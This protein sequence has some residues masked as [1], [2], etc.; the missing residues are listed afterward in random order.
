MKKILIFYLLIVNLVGYSQDNRQIIDDFAIKGKEL[1][2]IPGMSLV[3][4]END[5]T[6]FKSTYG[7][8]NY[9]TK[10]EVDDKTIFSMASTT[11]AFIGMGLGILVD[12]DSIGWNDKVV[13]HLPKFKLSD[14]Y[15]SNDARVKDLLTHNLGIGNEDRLWTTDSTSIDELLLNF[16]KSERKYSL[17]G[18]YTYQNIMY[19][20]AGRLIEKVSG[21]SWQDFI[22]HNI[23][24]PIGLECTLTWSKDIFEYGNHT[25]PH[26]IDYEEGIVN[27]P[28]TISDQ[29]GA[30]GMMWSC[31]D[32]MEKY[33]Y[34]LLNNSEVDGK[35]ILSEKTFNYIFEPQIIIGSS[36]YP[37]SKLTKPNWRTYG[38]GWFQHDYRGLKIDMHT[39]SL[40]GLVAIIAMVRDK[41][42]GLQ[43]FANMDGAELRHAL[44]YKIF[45]LLLFDDNSRD[46]NSEVFE[47]YKERSE[48]YKKSYFE[49]FENRDK[50][51]KLSYELED[52]VGKFS[53]DMYGDIHVTLL[54]RDVK[55][56]KNKYYLN[57][58][59]NNNIKNFDLEWWEGN[60]FLTDKDEKWLEKLFV[61]FIEE[62]DS[63]KSLK[64]Y[65]VEF[66]KVIN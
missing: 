12:R 2:Q 9:F 26:M 52:F 42:I 55:K 29:I 37:T 33:L 38:L 62:D 16:S 3:V 60:T 54:Q 59:V 31:L 41:N 7:V 57:L 1:W 34:F 56:S 36:F 20:V 53:N 28:F 8:K 61:D 15:I 14:P 63:I 5:S 49:S 21:Q 45:D 47:L 24:K 39:G 6:I 11:K 10:E 40:Q 46:W 4:V 22:E 35:R 25:Y 19:V 30:A 13:D 50:S 65:N 44:V 48:R 58:D 64:I 66:D 43:V 17:R 18:G 32:D 51:K 23:L 27:V